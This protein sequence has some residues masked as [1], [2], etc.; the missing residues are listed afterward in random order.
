MQKHGTQSWIVISRCIDKYVTELPKEN[1]KPI[2]CE[3][4]KTSEGQLVV[5]KQKEQL[6]PYSSSSATLPINQQTWNDISAVGR[7]GDKADKISK[8]MTRLLRHEGYPR[9]DDG[10]LEWRKL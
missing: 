4:V 9:E 10:A 2:Q 1:K 3:E 7:I 6:K 8:L 5:M